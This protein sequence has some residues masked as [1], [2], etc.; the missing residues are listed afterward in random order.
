VKPKK[1]QDD[2]SENT[3]FRELQEAFVPPPW[4]QAVIGVAEAASALRDNLQAIQ[5]PGGFFVIA[6]PAHLQAGQ[7][8]TSARY[9][10]PGPGTL[11]IRSGGLLLFPLTDTAPAGPLSNRPTCA[12]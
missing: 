4:C 6:L 1:C 12:P 7:G 2:C 5:A 3:R 11:S 9:R 10:H 8:P